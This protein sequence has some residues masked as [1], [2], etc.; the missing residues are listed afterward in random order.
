MKKN[1]KLFNFVIIILVASG[2]SYSYIKI[3]SD[4]DFN[5]KELSE[6]K[7]N[8]YDVDEN[9][10][11]N[12]G[13]N[14]DNYLRIPPIIN[15]DLSLSKNL[16][17]ASSTSIVLSD[18][19]FNSLLFASEK[20]E[21]LVQ[22]ENL[23][24][25]VSEKGESLVQSENPVGVV[26]EKGESLVQPENPVGVVSEKGESLVQPENPV[27]VVSQKGE[28]LVQPENPVGVVSQKGESLV[29]P[30]NPVGV[31]SE[32]GESLVQPENLVGVVSEK[33][34]SL[35]QPENPV[36]VVSEKG[37]SLVQPENPVAVVSEKGES[38]VQPEN[39]VAVVSE[40]GESLVQPENPVAVVSEK[41]ES[42]VQPENPVAVVSEKVES[43]VQPE[44][45]VGVVS[46][47]GESLVQP[48]NPVGVVSEKGESLVQPENPVAV[49]SIK[50]DSLVQPEKLDF[51]LIK[52]TRIEKIDIE[53]PYVR[54]PDM[55]LA[56]GETRDSFPG[57]KGVLERELEEYVANDGTVYLT[58]ILG[59][60]KTDPIVRVHRYG[61]L[62]K[63]EIPG[64]IGVYNVYEHF[65]NTDFS[66]LKL[67]VKSSAEDIRKLSSEELYSKAKGDYSNTLH[68][69]TK[70]GLYIP[71]A[72]PVSDS[73]I[74]GINSGVYFNHKL[75]GEEMLKLVNEERVRVGQKPL[76]WSDS[77]ANYAKLRSEELASNGNIRFFNEKNESM[78]HT[79]DNS[80][81]K[82]WTIFDGT[83]YSNALAGENTAAYNVK[84]NIYSL[85]SEKYIA[86][87][88]FTQWKNSPHH[89][90]NIIY[91]K[92]T[93][94]GFYI[95]ISKFWRDDK[96][97]VDYHFKGIEGVQL[98]GNSRF[99]D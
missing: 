51:I 62:K 53:P 44:N 57:V 29:Q 18:K 36:A 86:E 17:E 96:Y 83:K 1:N 41:G 14:N 40:K 35:I 68:E 84:K 43:L 71:Y 2:S 50:G 65:P 49:V 15:D 34:E 28:S 70:P 19:L 25:V 80:G 61:T 30:E 11:D 32:K 76:L 3:K 95:Q 27:G 23:V 45:P 7:N 20:G 5:N 81:K 78:P 42:L 60:R 98:F 55:K 79:R 67:D 12:V 94:F 48:E 72:A 21:S 31:V 69:V 24:G 22:P 93:H 16:K 88:L 37:E 85:F 74:D 56:E 64:K 66:A 91:D 8:N 63:G 38:L 26:S 87:T 77:L 39:P 9:I 73:V 97:N 4:K 10:S 13:S 6:H 47:K 90:E 46:E 82:W 89:Y 58:K 75:L 92:Y 54:M 59:E 33:G 52:K 99:A